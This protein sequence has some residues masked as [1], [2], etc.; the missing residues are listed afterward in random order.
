MGVKT[1]WPLRRGIAPQNLILQVK[2]TAPFLFETE[3]P[4][5][6]QSY[7]RHLQAY[8][9]RELGHASYFELALRAHWATAGTYVPTDVDNAIREKLW[10]M[11]QPLDALE[12]MGQ[13]TL[14]A[15]SWDYL[16][17]TAR[18]ARTKAGEFL[19]TH[20]GTWFSVAAGAYAALR[21]PSPASARA[22]L[23][24]ITAEAER[25]V[26]FLRALHAEGDGLEVLRACALLAHNFGDL[27][28]VIDMWGLPSQDP[29]RLS[30]Y[31]AAHPASPLFGGWLA[32]A[33]RLN[34]KHMAA[35]NHR[36]YPLRAARC[37]RRKASYLLPVGP[38]LDAWGQSLGQDESL[39]PRDL[40]EV[41]CALVDGWQRLGSP[42]GYARALCGILETF[43]GGFQRLSKIIPA[44]QGRALKSGPLRA[45]C[46]L[47]RSRFE[48]QWTLHWKRDRPASSPESP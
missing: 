25:E 31:N 3:Y 44:R 32:Y 19:S 35:E 34:Q 14:E 41:V 27:D 18:L 11:A 17:V 4:A 38:F 40:S 6:R 47:S 5:P 9:G 22:I 24:A 28:R 20:E 26:A 10:K 1:A 43:P 37:L 33:G 45:L 30:L 2:N 42:L 8:D 13:I 36:H 21:G 39:S 12:Q 29:L 48:T 15:L 16:P 7:L 23:E 46:C